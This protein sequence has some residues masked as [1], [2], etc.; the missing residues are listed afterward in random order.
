MN[1][2]K[3]L[4]LIL[5]AGRG[6]RMKSEIPKPLNL[7]YNRPIISWIINSFKKENIDI[8]LI[9]NPKDRNHFED[10][11]NQVNFIYQNHPRGTGHAVIQ[12]KKTIIKYNR[13]FV[14]VGDSPFVSNDIISKMYNSHLQNKSYCTILSSNF[15]EKKFPYARIIRKNESIIKVIEQ[16][17]A[18]NLELQIDELFCSHYLFESR[19]LLDYLNYLK[20]H[21]NNKEIYLT[22][23]L[24]HIISNK[25]NINSIII[26]DWKCLVGLNT[27]KDIAWI[28]SQKIN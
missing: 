17:D 16:K 18:T 4:A 14:F 28:E 9:I 3:V 15:I 25:K 7:V 21:E 24:N 11:K 5:A 6:T 22:D 13:T 1:H 20:P 12:A 26:K 8:G 19:V 10:Y 2:N 27:K 23:I